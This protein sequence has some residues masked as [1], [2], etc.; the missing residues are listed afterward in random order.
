MNNLFFPFVKWADQVPLRLHSSNF[1]HRGEHPLTFWK[2]FAIW[3]YA[4]SSLGANKKNWYK[5]TQG[6]KLFITDPSHNWGKCFYD[7]SSGRLTFLWRPSAEHYT[8]V[9]Q[10]KPKPRNT[11][12]SNTWG[13]L[14][15]NIVIE[16]ALW[17]LW[18]VV[19]YIWGRHRTWT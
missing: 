5:D 14:G 15:Q 19:G 6:R 1:Q 9:R 7:S 3:L 18:R 16:Q 10:M 2:E 12:H 13:A 8:W 11:E 4:E 17:E